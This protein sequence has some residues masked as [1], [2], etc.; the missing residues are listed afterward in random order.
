[1]AAGGQVWSRAAAESSHP[2]PQAGGREGKGL[3]SIWA[4]ET[5]KPASSDTPPPT[6]PRLPMISKNTSTNWRPNIQVCEPMREGLSCSY[7]RNPIRKL[8]LHSPS[9]TITAASFSGRRG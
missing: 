3:T 5:A 2:D 8:T 1:M 9:P 7:R 4:F 6:R